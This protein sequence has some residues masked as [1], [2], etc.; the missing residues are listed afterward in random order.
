MTDRRFK[1][2]ER[3]RGLEDWRHILRPGLRSAVD[4]ALGGAERDAIAEQLGLTTLAVSVRLS[5]AAA[6]ME[7]ARD[8]KTEPSRAGPRRAAG[9]RRGGVPGMSHLAIARALGVS[10][11]RVEQIEARALA[12]LARSGTLRDLV[13]Q[14]G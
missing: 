13:E 4:L 11:T 7:R 9:A 6:R 3:L 10:K 14:R 2:L 5:E 8:G 1:V 12:K